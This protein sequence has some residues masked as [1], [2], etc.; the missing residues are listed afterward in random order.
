MTTAIS[1][2][3]ASSISVNG[4]NS[5][6][7]NGTS[8]AVAGNTNVVV[9]FPESPQQVE[10]LLSRYSALHHSLSNPLND[11]VKINTELLAIEKTLHEISQQQNKYLETFDQL[12]ENED[13]SQCNL[14]LLKKQIIGFNLLTK[15]LDLPVSLQVEF[16]IN[17]DYGEP[18]ENGNEQCE[19]NLIPL[20][21]DYSDFESRYANFLTNNCYS[22]LL[23]Q[24]DIYHDVVGNKYAQLRLDNKINDRISQLESL[25]S[26]LGTIDTDKLVE[27]FNKPVESRFDSSIDKLKINALVELKSLRLLNKQKQLRQILLSGM[28]RTAHEK[29]SVYLKSSNECADQVQD[30]PIVLMAKRL[31]NLRIKVIAPQTARLAEQLEAKKQKELQ[32]IQKREKLIKLNHKM[33]RLQAVINR[34]SEPKYVRT[35]YL[36][37]SI[38]SYHTQQEK[39]AA[40]RL[41]RTAKE[42]LQALKANDEEAYLKLLDQTKDTRITHL[43]RQT[44]SFLDSLAKAVKVQQHESKVMND[45]SEN[46]GSGMDEID[47]EAREKIDYYSIAHRV[48]EKIAKQAS[49]L[50]GGKLKEYQLK[51]LEWMVSLYN[52]HLNGI[53]ADEMGLGKTIQSISLITYLIESKKEKL[54]FLVIVPL[55]TITNWTLECERWA[56]SV[57]KI[58]YKGTPNQRKLLANEFRRGDFQILLTTYE[59]IIKD[60]SLLAKQRYAHMIIDEGHRM[61]NAQSKLSITLS[62][63]YHTKHRLILTGTPL[64]N[65]LPELWALLN[66]VLPKV[67]NSV[68]TFDEWFNTPFANS[69]SQEK[70]ELSEEESLLVIRRLHKVLRPFLLRRLKKDVEKDLPDKIEKVVKCQFSGLQ[71]ALYQQMLRHNALFVGAS[72]NNGTTRGG[73]KGLNNKIMQLRKICNHPYVFEEVEDLI[74]PTRYLN[75]SLW[76]SSGKFELLDRVLPKFKA[77]GHRVLMFF[78]MTSVMDIMEDYLRYRSMSYLRLDGGTKADERQDMLKLFNA[79]NSDIFCFLLSTRAGGLGLNLQ[80][81]DTVIIFD[82]DWNPHQDLQAQDRAHRIGQKNEV[83]ILRLIT[84]DSVEEIILER[85]HEKLNIDGKVIQ[86]GKFDNKSTAEE[87]E[88]FLRRLLEAEELK[89]KGNGEDEDE[90]GLE[91]EELNDILARND[92]EKLLFA[93]M[94]EERR[95]QDEMD[96]IPSRLISKGELPNVF[97]EETVEK[98]FNE[99][100]E[101]KPLEATRRRKAVIYDDG[102]TEEQ[103]LEAMDSDTEI[104]MEEAILKKRESMKKRR[105]KQQQN[106]EIEKNEQE[107]SDLDLDKED[108]MEDSEEIVKKK[109]RKRSNSEDYVDE[110]EDEKDEIIEPKRIKKIKI[111]Q[112]TEPQSDG[113]KNKDVKMENGHINFKTVDALDTIATNNVK[114]VVEEVKLLT[115]DNGELIANLFLKVPSKALY[116]DYYQIVT[117]PIS[118]HEISR[119]LKATS[120]IRGKSK[121]NLKQGYYRSISEVLEDFKLMLDNAFSYNEP[122]SFVCDYAQKIYDYVQNT[123]G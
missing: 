117:S 98:H 52:N 70:L 8:S 63:Y 35:Q 10:L 17:S 99:Q 15:D 31:L 39:E 106:G 7:P 75:D 41:E 3:S 53:L 100:T 101:E 28:A 80:T 123:L 69:G 24:K 50:V 47:D 104:T 118:I 115:D 97:S 94:D 59:Y 65:N 76:R 13:N 58:V 43:L 78:Q 90:V 16:G 107:N 122:E 81:A 36:Q 121:K 66:F 95:N 42:R 45:S 21:I 32:I 62:T 120:E 88:A 84:N 71:Y 57:K 30:S 9:P 5:S 77:S 49:I 37:K 68:K 48:E 112:L 25:P 26:N 72:I 92:D 73:I 102:L 27:N 89:K 2:P 67:F 105:E 12:L 11:S 116:P 33:D 51:G 29:T 19:N 20:E 86:A 82:T 111:K 6:I 74:N 55:S 1:T 14:E 40:K 103:W 87:Q 114:K 56:P 113:V 85:A 23:K 93:K 108:S 83:R 96:G 79:P 4:G 61:K 18:S 110:M 119:K 44:N 54:P 60:K 91:D 34:K 64:Q 46:N 109:S 22:S 38:T